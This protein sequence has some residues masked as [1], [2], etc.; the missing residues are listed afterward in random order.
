MSKTISRRFPV[1]STIIGVVVRPLPH[2]LFRSKVILKQVS[3]EVLLTKLTAYHNFS[4]NVFGNR[5][6]KSGKRIHIFDGSSA[7]SCNDIFDDIEV[8]YGLDDV[9]TNMLELSYTT[10]I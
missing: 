6:I 7:L 5:E 2:S 9:V 4:D 8:F 10:C 3:D 1:K